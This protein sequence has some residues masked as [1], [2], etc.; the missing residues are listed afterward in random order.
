M[1]VKRYLESFLKQNIFKYSTLI[2]SYGF[3]NIYFLM[4]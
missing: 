1:V 4:L 2:G 3:T